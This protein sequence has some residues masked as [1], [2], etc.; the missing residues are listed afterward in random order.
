MR[1]SFM[2]LSYPGFDFGALCYHYHGGYSLLVRFSS[3]KIPTCSIIMT[4]WQMPS[5]S[6]L[7]SSSINYLGII[8][9]PNKTKH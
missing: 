3:G 8:L 6:L 2:F 4:P 5:I 1:L 9:S 7:L